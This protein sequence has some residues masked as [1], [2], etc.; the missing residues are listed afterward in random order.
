MH[1]VLKIFFPLTH[2]AKVNV[3]QKYAKS[4]EKLYRW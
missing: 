3:I 2:T 1:I 4:N